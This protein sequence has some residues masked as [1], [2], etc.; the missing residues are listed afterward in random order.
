MLDTIENLIIQL[1]ARFTNMLNQVEDIA[2][3]I[4]A[5]AGPWLTPIPT[6]YLVGR[7][8]YNH[9][10]WPIWVSIPSA[11]AIE[12]LGLTTITTALRLW[13]YNKTKRKSDPVAP[14]GVAIFLTGCYLVVA[15][16][17]TIVIDVVEGLRFISPAI[18][19]LL[20]I[21]AA[22][23]I[24]LRQGHRHRVA[25]IEQDKEEAKQKRRERYQREKEEKEE[26]LRKEET[27]SAICEICDWKRDGYD[28]QWKAENALRR[29]M[30]VHDG[31]G[32]F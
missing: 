27:F 4:A 7:A 6:A 24:A 19:P 14:F 5:R 8:A 10:Q 9:F 3:D 32:D 30:T 16:L 2:I 23:I 22:S 17:L 13:E 1:A 12:F 29:H 20:S 26:A 28:E 21:M 11:V 25:E 31:E 15:I 18:F